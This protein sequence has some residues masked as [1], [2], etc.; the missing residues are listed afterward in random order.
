VQLRISGLCVQE[1]NRDC[2]AIVHVGFSYLRGIRQFFTGAAFTQRI[3]V[4]LGGHGYTT[5]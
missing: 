3:R 2:L 5:G 4:A 1:E